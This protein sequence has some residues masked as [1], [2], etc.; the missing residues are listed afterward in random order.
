MDSALTTVVEVVR[1]SVVVA[2]CTS[3]VVREVS[4]L[5]GT[6][7]GRCPAAEE[8]DVVDEVVL[9]GAGDDDA[10]LDDE[11]DALL[12]DGDDAL[13]DNE[14]DALLDKIDDALVDGED[15]ALVD[16]EDDALL[17]VNDEALL[18]DCDTAAA[19][20]TVG[21]PDSLGSSDSKLVTVV[22]E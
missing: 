12:D 7:V 3:E 17:D 21:L 13:V 5:S 14:D 2:D 9:C 11:D 20:K 19:E 18:N 4:E 1:S 6:L 8:L 15:D 10:L 16:D 22:V